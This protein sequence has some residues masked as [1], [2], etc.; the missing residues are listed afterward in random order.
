[1]ELKEQTVSSSLL[2]LL[3]IRDALPYASFE[4]YTHTD[5]LVQNRLNLSPK[6]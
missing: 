1:M 5:F 2:Q 3:S 4:I 6:R